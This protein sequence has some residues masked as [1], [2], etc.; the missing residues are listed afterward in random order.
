MH[1]KYSQ[2]DVHL[3][4]DC[5]QVALGIKIVRIQRH[6]AFKSLNLGHAFQLLANVKELEILIV[7]HTNFLGVSVYSE[8]WGNVNE[9]YTEVINSKILAKFEQP[10]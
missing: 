10:V 9:Q 8:K 2:K 7:I 6:M 1:I 5:I 3:I 4:C